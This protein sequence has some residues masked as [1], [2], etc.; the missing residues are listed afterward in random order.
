[1]GEGAAASSA[2]GTPSSSGSAPG[3]GNKRKSPDDTPSPAAGS[4]APPGMRKKKRKSGSATPDL[5][6]ESFPGMITRDA[7]LAWLREQPNA[8]PMRKAVETWSKAITSAPTEFKDRNK[9]RFLQIIK[10]LTDKLPDQHLQ[11]KDEY[12]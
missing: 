5:D 12:R 3:M 10:V 9:T 7:V 1:M 2:M 8:F 4:P 6:N 11:L